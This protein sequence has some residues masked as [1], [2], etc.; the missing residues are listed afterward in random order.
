M[1]KNKNFDDKYQ[2]QITLDVK[3][4]NKGLDS[5]NL[6]L[7]ISLPLNQIVFI[8][9]NNQFV[10]SLTI[11]MVIS[12]T[13]NKIQIF[14]QAWN[15]QIIEPYYDNT[16]DPDNYYRTEKN[17][18]LMPGNYTLFL[19][20]QDEDSRKNWAITKNIVID[21]IDYISD[22]ILFIKN[23]MGKMEQVRF[24]IEKTDTIWLR[25]QI[26]LPEQ[27]PANL[28]YTLQHDKMDVDSGS[29]YING[30][31][32]D[33][34][35]FLPIPMLINNRGKHIIKL[36]LFDETKSIDFSYGLKIKKYWTADI[37]EIVGVMKIIL[38][39]S[40]Y[41]KMKELDNTEKWD[42]VDSYW[43]ENDP[44]SNTEENELLEEFNDRVK[45][46]IKNFSINMPGWKSDRG[47]VYIVYGEPQFIDNTYQDNMG[48]KYQKWLY[49][50]GKEFIFIDRTMSGDY[51]LLEQ[52]F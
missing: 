24:V 3:H 40:K 44:S 29:V 43:E 11:T 13:D 48:L 16:R 51:N 31:G 33:N 38:P 20:I 47:K 36:K 10:S 8:K 49:P 30:M 2:S 6:N 19:N 45:F 21:K 34:L 14:R 35:Y 37:D 4:W 39:Y 22:P 42:M 25:S 46:S 32:I 18:V 7:N 28:K 15:D 12:N 52:K 50:N 1:N 27:S 26:N 9:Q 17:I 5:L 23:K 41:K